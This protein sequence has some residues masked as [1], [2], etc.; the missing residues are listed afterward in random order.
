[1]CLSTGNCTELTQHTS[2]VS[3]M[4]AGMDS[5]V[6]GAPRGSSFELLE[7][8]VETSTIAGTVLCNCL[9]SCPITIALPEK[10]LD[11]ELLAAIEERKEAERIKHNRGFWMYFFMRVLASGSVS[12][13]F[14]M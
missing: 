6:E 7:V 13:A 5:S 9:T 4:L 12:V 10:A 3:F 1:M 8:N 2:T 11:E 14:S